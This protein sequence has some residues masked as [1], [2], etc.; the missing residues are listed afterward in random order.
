MEK[1]IQGLRRFQTNYVATHRDLFEQLSKGQA[2]RVLFITCSDSRVDPE[3]ITQAQVGELFVIR[4][5]GNLIPPYRAA[6]GG[7][8][9]TLEYAIHALGVQQI[10]VCGH[11]RCG[12]M[13]G[14]MHMDKLKEEMPLVHDWL[15]H[16]ESTRRLVKENY[17]HCNTDDLIDIA[18]AENV[19]GQLDNLNTYPVVR[20]KLHQG[21]LALHGWIYQIES[22]E[23]LAY[24]AHQHQFVPP[25]SR[26]PT[27]EPVFRIHPTCPVP[28]QPAPA[29]HPLSSSSGTALP[30]FPHLPP[31]QIERI[32]RGSSPSV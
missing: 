9:A 6:N 28:D 11:T 12:A 24:D 17:G 27:P 32:Y 23:V 16:A 25:H 14:L 29:H 26:M 7:E 10:V 31:H 15:L 2:P 3:L 1:L 8:G 19:L 5:A 22:G 20:T 18:V 30:G 21:K 13:K 4:N